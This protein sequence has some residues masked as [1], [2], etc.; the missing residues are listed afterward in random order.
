MYGMSCQPYLT[1]RAQRLTLTCIGRPH[2]SR[3]RGGAV[4]GGGLCRIYGGHISA[5]SRLRDN[6]RTG[7]WYRAAA[8]VAARTISGQACSAVVWNIGAGG[9]GAVCGVAALLLRCPTLRL[10]NDQHLW[11]LKDI[12]RCCSAICVCK[13]HNT[14]WWRVTTHTTPRGQH[15]Q[16]HQKDTSTATA[17]WRCHQHMPYLILRM[18]P[19]P[20]RQ[21]CI[22]QPG[23][24][25]HSQPNNTPPP[26]TLCAL[27]GKQ[28]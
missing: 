11:L 4:V 10:W 21:T 28:T 14:R 9:V 17:P 20:V 8:V 2:H 23:M 15:T 25:A 27:P 16:R 6:L 12:I 26:Q 5:I 1:H 3:A 24:P 13:H 22:M 7:W 19:Y 18:Q